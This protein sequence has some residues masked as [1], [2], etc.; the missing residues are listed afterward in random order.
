[1]VGLSIVRLLARAEYLDLFRFGRK[2]CHHGKDS[3]PS[4]LPT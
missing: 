3:R 4:F 2:P 1:M